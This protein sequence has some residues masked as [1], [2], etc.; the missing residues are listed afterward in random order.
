MNIF[1]YENW[2]EFSEFKKRQVVNTSIC[3]SLTP[4]EKKS[5]QVAVERAI[6][7][8]SRGI[9][10][11]NSTGSGGRK[12]AVAFL[13]KCR[14]LWD[15]PQVPTMGT[16]GYNLYINSKFVHSLSDDDIQAILCHEMFHIALLHMRRMK[17]VTGEKPGKQLATKWNIAADLEIN[18]ILVDEQLITVDGLKKLHACYEEKYI[19]KSAEEIYGLLGNDGMPQPPGASEGDE[20]AP[21]Q[22]GDYIQTDKKDFGKITKVNDD[23]TYE[24]DK[25]SDKE[26]DD[27]KKIFSASK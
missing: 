27:L 2:K 3:E 17:N 22:V 16:D 18:P 21:A 4:E 20:Y 14:I 7:W 11:G 5:A 9:S 1:S 13:L 12:F 24:Y 8:M 19:G 15:H 23:G 10:G 6:A 25:L 26:V